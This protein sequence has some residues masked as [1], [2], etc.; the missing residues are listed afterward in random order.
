MFCFMSDNTVMLTV[1]VINIECLNNK[2]STQIQ[3]NLDVVLCQL[4]IIASDYQQLK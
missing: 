3:Y 2:V 4:F 1:C